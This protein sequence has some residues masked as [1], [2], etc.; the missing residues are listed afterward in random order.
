MR[1]PPL[2]PSYAHVPYRIT[3]CSEY[4]SSV[5][6]QHHHIPPSIFRLLLQ[7]LSAA[8]PTAASQALLQDVDEYFLEFQNQQLPSGNAATTLWENLRQPQALAAASLRPTLRV[9]YVSYDFRAHPIGYMM[10][11]VFQYHARRRVRVAAYYYGQAQMNDADGKLLSLVDAGDPLNLSSTP[12]PRRMKEATMA[13]MICRS[14]QGSSGPCDV[15]GRGVQ[16]TKHAGDRFH[17]GHQASVEESRWPLHDIVADEVGAFPNRSQ[18]LRLAVAADRF[19]LAAQAPN[20]VLYQHW[21]QEADIV[22][23]LMGYTTNV[24]SGLLPPKAAP[25]I[26]NYLGFP[27]TLSTLPFLCFLCFCLSHRLPRYACRGLHHC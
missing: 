18:T 12:L 4:P 23:D 10:R 15:L 2:L 22:C 24:R 5:V 13:A 25:I 27:G 16:N 1:A 19:F 20:Q 11:G 7:Q 9:A 14:L 3:L 8:V 17:A 6:A 26:V 21:Q